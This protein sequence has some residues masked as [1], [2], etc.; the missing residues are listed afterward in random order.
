MLTSRFRDQNLDVYDTCLQ[1]SDGIHDTHSRLTSNV[2]TLSARIA[3]IHAS[4]AA[5]KPKLDQL[6][7]SHSETTSNLHALK[8]RQ[9]ATIEAM[10]RA[11]EALK[12]ET[13]KLSSAALNASTIKSEVARL[14]T[15]IV[16]DVSAL[17]STLVSLQT[18]LHTDKSTVAS[19]SL[20][21]RTLSTKNH[22]LNQVETVI[23]SCTLLLSEAYTAFT[24]LSQSVTNKES[25]SE[26]LDSKLRKLADLTSA[27]QV[28]FV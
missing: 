8:R 27:K 16:S 18:A 13:D 25:E 24:G 6:T 7:S 12:Q 9:T 4:R 22:V 20:K 19:L 1:R 10:T 26:T 21:S 2:S 3:A 5:Q 15:L 14:R 28:R 11:K 17:R 23:S